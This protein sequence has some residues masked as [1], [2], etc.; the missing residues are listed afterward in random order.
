MSEITLKK[1]VTKKADDLYVSVVERN[2]EIWVDVQLGEIKIEVNVEGLERSH[3]IDAD[4]SK[5]PKTIYRQTIEGL[6]DLLNFVL[7]KVVED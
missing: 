6:R 1:V 7:S 4:P 5:D 3:L 2:N